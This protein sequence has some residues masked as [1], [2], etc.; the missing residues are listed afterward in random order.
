MINLHLI[1]S[2]KGYPMG[3]FLL[4]LVG[5][6]LASNCIAK[7]IQCSFVTGGEFLST[8]LF[9]LDDTK[10][11]LT[12]I[13]FKA[14]NDHRIREPAEEVLNK[15]LVYN[16]DGNKI[17][18]SLMNRLNTTYTIDRQNA[19]IEIRQ[20]RGGGYLGGNCSVSAPPPTKS[21]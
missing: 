7:N 1:Y 11:T 20:G 13:E 8:L 18:V 12:L 10:K 16:Q 6:L 15:A 19:T 2:Y 21:F 17:V 4:L 14:P 5:T 3:K 9:K